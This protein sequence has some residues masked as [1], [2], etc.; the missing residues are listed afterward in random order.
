MRGR[1]TT[2]NVPNKCSPIVSR[3]IASF[4]TRASATFP[5]PPATAMDLP[6]ALQ[7]QSAT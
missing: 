5:S 2:F 7:A 3:A 4:A 6:S 1:Q